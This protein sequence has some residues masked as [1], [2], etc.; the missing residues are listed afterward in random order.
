MTAEEAHAAVD[1]ML[2][3]HES[4]RRARVVIEDFLDGEE[5]S[6]IVMVDGEHVLPMATSQDH[7][8]LLDRDQGP[9]RAAWR[10]SPLPSSRP[11]CTS[12]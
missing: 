10:Y 4:A 7:K 6:F 5:A 9:T 11:P 3:G 12:R 1:M 2:E 8:R